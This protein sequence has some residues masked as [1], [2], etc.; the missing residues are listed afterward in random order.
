MRRM[1]HLC[2]ADSISES[3]Q[4]ILKNGIKA[5][6]RSETPQHRTDSLRTDELIVESVREEEYAA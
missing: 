1:H 2:K 6:I 5:A 3:L 4:G